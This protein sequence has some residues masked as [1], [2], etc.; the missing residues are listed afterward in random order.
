MGFNIREKMQTNLLQEIKDLCPERKFN[1]LV[2]CIKQGQF[3]VLDYVLNNNLIRNEYYVSLVG[4]LSHTSDGI[5]WVIQHFS[6]LPLTVEKKFEII[7]TSDF[8]YSE[9]SILK[10]FERV[11]NIIWDG[12]AYT[13]IE[14]LKD[15]V[16]N[17]LVN[18]ENVNIY[19][20]E[21]MNNQ[22][23][24]CYRLYVPEVF[25]IYE[26]YQSQSLVADAREILS[27][28]ISGADLADEILSFLG[29]YDIVMKTIPHMS[30]RTKNT[31]TILISLGM[32]K[33]IYSLS[34]ENYY[35]DVKH[36]YDLTTTIVLTTLAVNFLP[37]GMSWVAGL[38]VFGIGI[39]GLKV[40]DIVN[41]YYQN[42]RIEE[43][44]LNKEYLDVN[45]QLRDSLYDEGY[46]V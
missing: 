33:A 6:E 40:F 41:E 19:I 43:D 24:Q 13:T 44:T 46:L 12:L 35:Y 30:I 25:K 9:S 5:K 10:Y 1:L 38:T 3:Y 17:D 8:V 18:H 31:F 22:M 27:E 32:A 45:G 34:Q 4:H 2:E 42:W 39:A 14:A 26:I 21:V 16:I 7:Y 11:T 36:I 29:P 28:H 23:V 37:M 20:Y 15:A